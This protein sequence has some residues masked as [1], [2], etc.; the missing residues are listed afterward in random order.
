M[1]Q[2][3]Q[4]G[5]LCWLDD[6]IHNWFSLTYANY[7]VVQRSVMCAMPYE[8]QQK[9]VALLDE[10]YETID[11]EKIPQQFRVNAVN[12]KGKFVKDPFSNYRH[13][14]PIPMRQKNSPINF[15]PN[16]HKK[17]LDRTKI[18]TARKRDKSGKFTIDGKR[19]LV[20]FE[21][22]MTADAFI[23]LFESDFYT[24][25]QFGFESSLSMW[26]YYSDYF[27]RDELIYVHKIEEAING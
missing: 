23:S 27:L 6:P 24:P 21:I 12:A 7:L 3:M 19:F 13:P 2:V 18:R 17:I 16:H 4:D 1:K 25:E 20:T 5:K 22:A 26:T 10:M 14:D 11:A 8:W 15:A 9:M